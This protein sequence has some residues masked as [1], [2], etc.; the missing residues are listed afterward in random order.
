MHKTFSFVKN[1]FSCPQLYERLFVSASGEVM[2]CNSDEYGEEVVGNAYDQTIYEIWHG[3]KLN[4]IR[5]LHKKSNGF[6][7]IPV[8]TK[9][10]YPR[11]TEVS[12]R[13][14]INGREMLIENYLNRA[15]E[16]GK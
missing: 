1:N 2:M 12:E 15:Q 16:I 3:K 7:E 11:K 8:C 6:L 10:F 5:D 14:N 9:C 4:R 13:V